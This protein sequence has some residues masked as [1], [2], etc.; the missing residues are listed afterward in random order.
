MLSALG[1]LTTRLLRVSGHKRVWQL[2][3]P[4]FVALPLHAQEILVLNSPGAVW[5]EGVELRI[6]QVNDFVGDSFQP[7]PATVKVARTYGTPE[8]D[9][10]LELLLLDEAYIPVELFHEYAH[11]LLDIYLKQQ[12]AAV[13]YFELRRRIRGKP[14]SEKIALLKEEL[15]DDRQY[16]EELKQKGYQKMAT[17]LARAIVSSNQLLDELRIATPLDHRLAAMYPRYTG[18][19]HAPSLYRVLAPYHELFADTLAALLTN[20]WD[21]IYM[22]Q[23]N[24]A[25][26][27]DYELKISNKHPAMNNQNYLRYRAFRTDI[28]LDSYEFSPEEAHSSYTQFA[29]TRAY[30]RKLAE[31][32]FNRDRSRLIARLAQVIAEELDARLSSPLLYSMPLREKNRRLIKRLAGVETLTAD[33]N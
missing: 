15:A 19:T 8:Y 13:G 29:P 12:V 5:K 6:R 32:D 25:H 23:I 4:L 7:L 20:Q 21:S 26:H 17:N 33:A 14:V 16:L 22:A 31:T 11:A 28:D 1:S 24:L 10:A 9:L 3:A 30:I 2:L 27:R 18:H